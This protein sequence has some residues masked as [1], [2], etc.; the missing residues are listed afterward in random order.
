MSF[1]VSLNLPFERKGVETWIMSQT[2][3]TI[4]DIF[5]HSQL[6]F[7]TVANNKQE[8]FYKEILDKNQKEI[9][10]L[11]EEKHDL[12]TNLAKEFEK[13][14]QCAINEYKTQISVLNNQFS[15]LNKQILDLQEEKQDFC[16]K[17]ER[18]HEEKLKLTQ[19]CTEKVEKLT[20]SLT[21]TSASIGAF[22]EGFVKHK[23]TSMN[24]G[25]YEDD[26]QNKNA[27]FADGTWKYS[28]ETSSTPPISCLVEVKNKKKLEKGPDFDKFEKTDVPAAHNGGRINMA[29]FI[30]LIE[31]ISGRNWISLE[32]K[33]GV[34][35]LWI[36]RNSEDS[37]SAE[38]LVEI[39]FRTM[40][41]IWPTISQQSN[42]DVEITLGEVSMHIETQ[43]RELE[44]LMKSIADIE[45]TGSALIKKATAM[46]KMADTMEGNLHQLRMSDSRLTI[47]SN[48]QTHDFW[49]NEGESLLQALRDYN[50][51]KKRHATKIE[52]LKLNNSIVEKTLTVPNAFKDALEKVKV[53]IQ[54]TAGVKRQQ[55]RLLLETKKQKVV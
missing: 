37:I 13:E 31:R 41:Q 24:L 50:T 4:A 1:I 55:A 11:I 2:P 23:M 21:G 18:L 35:T 17:N 39:A 8:S 33:L 46:K 3:D 38:T 34:P 47:N 25:F 49:N 6:F 28:Y 53:E 42:K 22:G 30:S 44:T 14:H 51:D 45:K 26:S 40:A 36:S 54:R 32:T 16:H 5:E 7:T 12:K 19:D 43:L 29:M 9:N 20:K 52:D 48:H 10:K 15:I 27:G